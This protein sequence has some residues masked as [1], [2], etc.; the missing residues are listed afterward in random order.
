MTLSTRRLN[1]LGHPEI[2]FEI[3]PGG[4]ALSAWIVDYLES[5]VRAGKQF[6]DGQTIQIGWSLLLVRRVGEVLELL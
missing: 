3:E 1:V 6:L 5:E 2:T 4:A